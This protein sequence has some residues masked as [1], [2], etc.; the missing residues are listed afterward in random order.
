MS[1]ATGM[2]AWRRAMTLSDLPSMTK[3]VL[4]VIAE[5][6]NALDDVCWP[7]VETIAERS[8]LSE[9]GVRKHLAVAEESGWLSKWKS[10][11]AGRRWAHCLY[12]LVMPD[13]IAASMVEDPDADV[14]QMGFSARDDQR[15][16]VADS[17]GR[18]ERGAGDDADMTARERIDREDEGI[19]EESDGSYRHEVPTNNPRYRYTNK[20]SLSQPTSVIEGNGRQSVDDETEFS[21]ARWMW[22]T[23][24]KRLPGMRAPN[25]AAWAK[26]VR[27][28]LD[29]DGQPAEHIARLFNWTQRDRF[30]SGVI[31][32]PAKLGKHWDVIRLKRNASLASAA[33]RSAA[34]GG[35][36]AVPRGGEPASSVDDRRCV[37]EGNGCRCERMATTVVGAGAWRRGYCREHVDL[38]RG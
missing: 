33:V 14:S 18:T 30:W 1:T 9:R 10:R 5:Y 23:V 2:Y 34:A 17:F 8:S 13:A 32:S 3:L 20:P 12:R 15:A 6:A 24:K 31:S 26:D 37:H 19:R 21:M 25:L 35:A 28:L 29:V 16:E 11:R 36:A 7:S 22:D 27:R 4:F 38:Y